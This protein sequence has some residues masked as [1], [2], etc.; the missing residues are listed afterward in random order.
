MIKCEKQT[1]KLTAEII[2]I[3]TGIFTGI[4][5]TAISYE[6][7]MLEKEKAAREEE[8]MERQ[9]NREDMKDLPNMKVDE[10]KKTLLYGKEYIGYK[11]YD[12]SENTDGVSLDNPVGVI[13]IKSKGTIIKVL[14]IK[15][16]VRIEKLP[17]ETEQGIMTFFVREP[18]EIE[19]KIENIKKEIKAYMKSDGS[20]SY[21][22]SVQF[23]VLATVKYTN[24]SN[25]GFERK[26][27]IFLDENS[28]CEV[29]EDEYEKCDSYYLE[30]EKIEQGDEFG[31]MIHEAGERIEKTKDL[32]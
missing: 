31:E 21:E 3:I 30:Y 29:V 26:Y 24:K 28:R 32:D 14:L 20:E 2:A 23:G 18:E 4:I 8:N 11:V 13:V 10:G 27:I 22:Y 17:L 7:L 12:S 5:A 9:Q 16:S 6:K 19:M 25:V 15:S 1:L